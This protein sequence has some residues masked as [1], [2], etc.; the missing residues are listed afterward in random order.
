MSDKSGWYGT[1]IPGS[2]YL[3]RYP[4]DWGYLRVSNSS[5]SVIFKYRQ[6]TCCL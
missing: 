6:K 3:Q 1:E 2:A 5:L 4:G